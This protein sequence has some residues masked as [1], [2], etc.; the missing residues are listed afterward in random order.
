MLKA[1]GDKLKN[2]YNKVL[3][4]MTK[5]SGNNDDSTELKS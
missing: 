1:I 3:E 2:M 4:E 5:K